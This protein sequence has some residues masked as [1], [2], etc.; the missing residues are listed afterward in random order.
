MGALSR[1]SLAALLRASA[2][3]LFRALMVAGVVGILSFVMMRTLPGDAAYR[4]AAARYGYDMVDTAAAQA[5]RTELGLDQSAWVQLLEWLSQLVQ[6]NLGRSLV[7]GEPVWDELVHQ[8]GHTIALA[9]SAW[10][11]ALVLGL[12]GGIVIAVVR[13]PWLERLGLVLALTLRACPSFVVGLLLA[14]WLAVYANVLPAAG[15]GGVEFFVLPTLTLALGL[16][17]G[18]SMVTQ[19]TLQQVMASPWVQFASTK[20]LRRPVVVARHVL[21]NAAVPVTAYAGTQ[22][23]L[24][25][26]GVVVVESFFA[27][28]GVGH[29]L[30][31]ALI[32]RDI[33]MVQGAALC[34]GGMFVL[35][36]ALVDALCWLLDP[37]LQQRE[38]TP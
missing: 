2:R 15:H 26:E 18:L 22:L 28:P 31:H 24:L 30:V 9:W 33:P 5:V 32:A 16:A 10:S 38:R 4:I 6:G 8:L 29:A 25:I 14:S 7:S 20:G 23:V 21:R 27:W 34:M 12:C 1:L 3:L 11:L 19:Q 17:A 13:R 37:R 36:S 35:L